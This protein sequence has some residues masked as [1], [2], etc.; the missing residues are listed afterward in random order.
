MRSGS[1]RIRKPRRAHGWRIQIHSSVVMGLHGRR[2]V[3]PLLLPTNKAR[4][5]AMG[6]T[7]LP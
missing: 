6:F 2:M 3:N 1:L 4:A 7:A 5:A